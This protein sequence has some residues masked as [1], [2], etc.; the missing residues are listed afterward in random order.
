MQRVQV[1]SVL[2]PRGLRGELKCR[3]FPCA[4]PEVIYI[5]GQAINVLNS[6]EYGG[7]TYL[8]L[9]GVTSIETA[10]RLR[11]KE[12]FIDREELVL[13]DDEILST[14][15]IGYS[16]LDESGKELGLVK[17]IDNYG[18]GDLVICDTCIIP[19]E[20]DFIIETNIKKRTLV[21]RSLE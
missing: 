10:E 5:D 3:Q 14:E 8:F 2:K 12:I 18:A 11:N 7:N 13:G 15:L 16:V 6:S 1:S 20:D 9:S 19:Y 21:V 17:S 4:V